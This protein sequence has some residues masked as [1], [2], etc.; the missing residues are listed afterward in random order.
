MRRTILITT[1]LAGGILAGLPDASAQNLIPCADEGQNCRVPFP[2]RVYYGVPGRTLNRFVQAG[3]L[4]CSNESF[5]GD[6]APRVRKT[7]G[8]LPQ[9][10]NESFDRPRGGRDVEDRPRRRDVEDDG[11]RRRR[12]F[13]DRPRRRDIDDEPP[14]RRR[15]LDPEFDEAPRRPRF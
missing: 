4:P 8:Y 6:P 12:E 10:A 5:G 3:N 2:T 15:D 14:R 7:C 1:I 9:G 11:P 13:E